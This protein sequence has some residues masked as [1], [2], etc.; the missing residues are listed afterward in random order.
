MKIWER[1]LRAE[2]QAENAF[3]DAELRL[4]ALVTAP[5]KPTMSKKFKEHLLKETEPLEHTW[6]NAKPRCPVVLLA[7]GIK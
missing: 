2:E 6:E 5:R 1:I 3:V 4:E 7:M